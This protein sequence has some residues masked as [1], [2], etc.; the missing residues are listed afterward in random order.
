MKAPINKREKT[1]YTRFL[2]FTTLMGIAILLIVSI[3]SGA[4]KIDFSMI[5]D[6]LFRF[7]PD[8]A[9]HLLI[10]EFRITRALT[11]VLIGAALGV[12]GAI[13]QA[14]T[15][16]PLADSGLLGLSSG[17]SLSLTI[18]LLYF[19]HFT[20]HQMMGMSFLGAFIGA[21]L[22]YLISQF[23]PGNNHAM[24]LILSGAMISTL[25]A[26]I[27]RGLAL[28]GNKSQNIMIWTMGSVSGTTWLQLS[29]GA[30]L[31]IPMLL[32]SFLHSR[33]LS[34]LS[35]GDE[36]AISLGIPLK[37]LKMLALFIVVMLSGVSYVLGGN[38]IFVGMMAPHFARFLVGSDYRNIIPLSGVFGGILVLAADVL[39]KTM[40]PPGELPLGTLISLL[41]VPIF[42]YFAATI[43][44]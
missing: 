29:M 11:A 1:A 8:N 28:Q 5:Q 40:N 22:V 2:F 25:L 19:Q 4:A 7:D 13:M 39:A 32:L 27:G 26:A 34:I 24:K 20:F 15:G 17:A 16:N 38:I 33:N 6:A 10:R 37:T 23:I 31:I 30:F 44:K 21:M 12:T 36:V 41:G 3:R 18:C 35:M 42:L 43:K 9:K 14:V